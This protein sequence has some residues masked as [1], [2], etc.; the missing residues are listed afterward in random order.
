MKITGLGRCTTEMLENALGQKVDDVNNFNTDSAS[1][2]QK[3]CKNHNIVLNA[4]PSGKHSKN[5]INISK[6]NNIH[7]QLET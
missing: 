7:S 5:D 3:F 6:I 2:Y 4:I 1:A